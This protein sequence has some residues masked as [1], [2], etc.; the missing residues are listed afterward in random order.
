MRPRT[1]SRGS[2]LLPPPPAPLPLRGR[3]PGRPPRR[4][5]TT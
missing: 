2:L 4:C 1:F 5:F 3:P